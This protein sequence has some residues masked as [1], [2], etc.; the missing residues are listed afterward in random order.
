[1]Y[2][3]IVEKIFIVLENIINKWTIGRNM[4]IKATADETEGMNEQNGIGNWRKR[5]SLL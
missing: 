1:M 5:V 2:E 4:D 3:C